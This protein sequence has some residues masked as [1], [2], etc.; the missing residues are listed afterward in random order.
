MSDILSISVTKERKEPVKEVQLNSKVHDF[1]TKKLGEET[2]AHLE[3]D[4][5]NSH[6]DIPDSLEGTEGLVNFQRINDIRYINKYLEA[7]NR[8][9]ENGQYLVVCLETKNARKVRILQKFPRPLNSIYY[10]LDFILKRVFPKWKPTRHLY[11]MITKGRNRVL[12]LTEG[13]A[14]LVCCGYE[15]E[16]FSRVGYNTFIIARKVKE[17]AYDMQPTYGALIRLKRVGKDGKLFNV[18]KV[19]TM[20]PYSEYLQDYVFEKHDLRDGGKLRNDFRMTSYGQFFRKYWIDELPMFINWFKGEMKLVGVR[21]L[22]RHYFE[23]YPEELQE[24]RTQVKPGLVPPFYADLPVTL[25]EIQESERRYLE[26]YEKRP[27][28]T[29]IEYFFK[30]FYNIFFRK[31]RSR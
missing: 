1:L 14:R 10:T 25:E 11:F 19:R 4:L 7:V 24:K 26:A 12:S 29:D 8:K 17:P 22:S 15:I 3:W 30:S 23:L 28:R 21:P 5:S 6:S 16:A 18:Y 27:F 13:L 31:A 9:L 2:V 20:H